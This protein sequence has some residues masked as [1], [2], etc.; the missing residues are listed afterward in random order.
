[1]RDEDV[2]TAC[3]AHLSVL[4]AEWGEDVP[5]TGGLDRGFPCRGRR[6]P[7]LNR[8]KGIYRAAVVVY[9]EDFSIRGTTRSE[10][11]SME[12]GP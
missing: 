3:M 6:V 4:V 10:L 7:F 12:R 8:Q 1:M 2:R 11:R 5:Y 9:H